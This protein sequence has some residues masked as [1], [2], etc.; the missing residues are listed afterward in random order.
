MKTNNN[1]FTIIEL[2]IVIVIIGIL[3][4]ITAV[5]YTGITNGANTADAQS[6]ARGVSQKA[7]ACNA[8]TGSWP[9]SSTINSCDGGGIGLPSGVKVVSAGATPPDT[10][11]T[12]IN[13]DPEPKKQKVIALGTAGQ[14]YYKDFSDN[15]A[16]KL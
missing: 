15:T 7:I 12:A 16:K 2:L 3:V 8:K 13:G 9:D 10:A 5:S 1:G 11:L 6:N 4:A 14:V